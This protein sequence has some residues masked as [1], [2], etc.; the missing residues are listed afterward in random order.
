MP[1][2]VH[3]TVDAIKDSTLQRQTVVAFLHL[4]RRNG[5]P[6]VMEIN[7]KLQKELIDL[8]RALSQ[9]LPSY[10]VPSMFLP[11]AQVPLTMN[12]KA[13]RRQLRELA[14]SLSHQDALLYSL[15][16]ATK[17]EPTTE[18][19]FKIRRLWASVLNLDVNE[20]GAGDH[21]FRLGGD[22]I[23]AMRL[24]TLARSEGL[25]LSVQSIFQTPVLADMAAK[26]ETESPKIQNGVLPV[27][28]PFSL[29]SAASIPKFAC[30]IAASLQ[31][32]PE[33]IAD[34][35]PA[36]GFQSSAMAHSILKTRGLLNYLFLDGEG[37]LPWSEID[38]TD[39]FTRFLDAHEILRTVFTVHGSQVYQV[40]YKSLSQCIQFYH[41]TGDINSF[42]TDLF[43][44]DMGADRN[45]G[46]SLTKIM[47]ISSPG[48]HR[49]VLRM[50]HAQYDGVSLPLIWR[51]L[52]E[53]FSGSK[54]APEVPFS[55]YLAN[56]SHL[57][58]IEKSRSYWRNLLTGS[59][60]TDVVAHSKP[61]YRNV[62]DIRLRRVI[63]NIS[64]T[65]SGITFASV[66]KSAWAIVLSSL[67][68]TSDVVFGH[69]TSGRNIPAQ[70]IERIVGPC[71]NIVPVRVPLDSCATVNDLLS[72]VQSQHV[73]TMTHESLGMRDIIRKCSPWANFTRFSSVVQHQNISEASAVTLGNNTY[74]IKDFCPPA[75]EADVA[76]KS[77]PIGDQIEVLLIASSRSTGESRASELLNLLCDVIEAIGSTS[78]NQIQLSKWMQDQPVLPMQPV[79]AT[80]NGFSARTNADSKDIEQ[81]LITFVKNS[82]RNALQEPELL[83]DLDSDFFSVGGD[84]VQIAI[85]AIVWQSQG[86]KVTAEDL[87]DH[88]HIHDMA[89]MLAE[90]N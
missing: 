42:C 15:A 39:A 43:R 7:P 72:F 70:D 33:N 2:L 18:M 61:S 83:L 6:E 59:A 19:E 47:V 79:L 78:S 14:A 9:M 38:A 71:I 32:N 69:V 90:S 88:P 48:C 25:G 27:Y 67:T 80:A 36:T 3:A 63:P 41:T 87:I 21:F 17:V 57:Y 28:S 16:D 46:E 64:L 49:L 37:Q 20:I 51:T 58:D 68:H 8:H 10:M 75:D 89:Q 5:N 29:V 77:T 45:P 26:I 73:A 40:V 34:I 22:S 50:S 74:S 1:S 86:Y 55:Q 60:M 24:T 4:S 23:I 85:L 53:V 76:I 44:Q 62:Y 82:W 13:D 84:L 35:L 31:T 66:L 56:V 81:D 65:S 12:G 11:M 30:E 54:P 52:G